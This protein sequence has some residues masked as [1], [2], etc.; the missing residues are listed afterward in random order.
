MT[1]R[2]Y[3]VMTFCCVTHGLLDGGLGIIIWHMPDIFTLQTTKATSWT[4][5]MTPH[6]KH[7]HSAGEMLQSISQNLVS[8]ERDLAIDEG[9]LDTESKKVPNR[10]RVRFKPSANEGVTVTVTVTVSLTVLLNCYMF[11]VLCF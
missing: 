8:L 3:G 7:V 11:H 2:R 1:S 9:I 10:Q 4:R 5:T 6:A